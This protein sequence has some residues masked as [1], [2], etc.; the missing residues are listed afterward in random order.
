MSNSPNTNLDL[1]PFGRNPH[2]HQPEWGQRYAIERLEADGKDHPSTLLLLE[3]SVVQGYGHAA[4]SK[5]VHEHGWCFDFSVRYP[6][7]WTLQN[8][9]DVARVLNRWWATAFRAAGETGPD[10]HLHIAYYGME[11]YYQ[12]VG[13]HKL[14]GH[15]VQDQIR[16]MLA[17]V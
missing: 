14:R 12:I 9:N 5:G 15:S 1:I 8:C 11:N 17:S 4:A 7:Q 6:H 13:K 16:A 3:Q 10:P 2:T